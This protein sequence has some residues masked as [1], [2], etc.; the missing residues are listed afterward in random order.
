MKGISSSALRE[1]ANL[2]PK[3]RTFLEEV[4]VEWVKVLIQPKEMPLYLM[5]PGTVEQFQS[6]LQ[7]YNDIVSLRTK[8]PSELQ[9]NFKDVI[10][11]IE[12]KYKEIL[13][14]TSITGIM[15]QTYYGLAKWVM[16]YSLSTLKLKG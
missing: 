7:K 4:E 15:S 5:G 8:I 12:K 11:D 9:N 3:L 2:T 14:E 13:L 10:K 6:E 16:I 1:L